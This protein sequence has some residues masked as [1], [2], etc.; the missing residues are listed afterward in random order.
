MTLL[1]IVIIVAVLILL[2]GFL[3]TGE[4][5]YVKQGK[6]WSSNSGIWIWSILGTIVGTAL[7]MWLLVS[8]DSNGS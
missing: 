2:Y 7:F 8:G 1:W 6:Y 3:R 5:E 4:P